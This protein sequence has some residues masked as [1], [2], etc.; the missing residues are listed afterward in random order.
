VVLPR[1][2]SFSI[3]NVMLDSKHRYDPVQAVCQRDRL[4]RQNLRREELLI[5]Q[6]C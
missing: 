1:C 6:K 2:E 5:V 4:N 3:L